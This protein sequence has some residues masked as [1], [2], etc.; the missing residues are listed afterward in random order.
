M[1]ESLE[2]LRITPAFDWRVVPEA[3][4]PA[5]AVGGLATQVALQ[6]AGVDEL[7]FRQQLIAMAVRGAPRSAALGD[8]VCI[9]A[10]GS[11]TARGVHRR[12]MVW[13]LAVTRAL[14]R[15]RKAP[16]VIHV[17]A[18]GLFEPLLAAIAARL[19]LRRPVVLTLH[20]SALATYVVQSRRDAVVQVFTRA[21]ER[22]AVRLSARTLVLTERVAGRLGR[23][24]ETMPDW[25]ELQRFS[26]LANADAARVFAE[27][28]AVPTDRPV[29]IYVGRIS[30]EKGWPALVT[31]ADKLADIPLH[32]LVCGDGDD[33]SAL[34]TAVREHGLESAFTFADAVSRDEVAAA[35]GCATLLV[36]P[37]SHEELGSVLIEAMAS[38]L[39]AVAYE[40]GGT[41]EAL[42]DG[43]TGTP[44][45]VATTRR[46]PRRRGG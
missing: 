8:R 10:V 18:S 25:V 42:V 14:L 41:A 26:P 5:D 9:E 29:A 40:V 24:A 28:Y 46:W 12:N 44:S 4:E 36:L 32:V 35:M 19:I 43:V 6:V 15:R 31:L 3:V 20:C 45:P 38:G 23:R 7:G 33:R 34:A 13:L 16:D 21:A 11:A 27:R 1:N 37:S 39:P 22:L 2:L 17:H 30:R